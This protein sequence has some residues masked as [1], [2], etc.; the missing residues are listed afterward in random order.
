MHNLTNNSTM[1]Y[2]LYASMLCVEMYI[3]KVCGL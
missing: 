2:V 3:V 1:T